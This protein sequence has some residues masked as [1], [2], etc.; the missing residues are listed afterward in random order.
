MGVNI[1]YNGESS[2]VAHYTIQ[3]P[4]HSLY[5]S[6]SSRFEVQIPSLQATSTYLKTIPIPFPKD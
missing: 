2:S 5:P 4:P 1:V 6:H 3:L